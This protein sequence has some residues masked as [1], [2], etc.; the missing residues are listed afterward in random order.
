MLAAGGR[1]WRRYGAVAGGRQHERQEHSAR[2]PAAIVEPGR[3]KRSGGPRWRLRGSEFP[4][5][6][7]SGGTP[8]QLPLLL[9]RSAPIRLDRPR[10]LPGAP[11]HTEHGPSRAHGSEL[12]FRC[13]RGADLCAVAVLSCLRHGVRPLRRAGQPVRLSGRPPDLSRSAPRRRLPHDGL[14]QAGPVEGKQRLGSG[15]HEPGRCLGL[16]RDDQQRRQGCRH[17]LSPGAVRPERPVL[18]LPGLSG[19][20][21]GADLR[22]GHGEAEREQARGLVGRHEPLTPRPR[23][24]LRQLDRSQRPRPARTGAGGQALAP[25]RELRRSS[26]AD[27]HHAGDG[28]DGARP[29]PCP[30]RTGP[31]PQLHG[32]VHGRAA[33]GLAPELRRDDREHR[34]VARPLHRLAGGEGAAREHDHRLLLGPRRDAR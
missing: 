2:V 23:G 20:A 3:R 4:G 8:A 15:R 24:V 22:R 16:L 34:H 19:T 14:R 26:S 7:R 6:G 33:P 1:V 28:P 11:G 18:R 27:G 30:R 31:S 29:R 17:V 5:T 32:L 13:L 25:G 9:P 12:H 10:R 21:A